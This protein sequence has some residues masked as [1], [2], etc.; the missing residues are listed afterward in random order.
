MVESYCMSKVYHNFNKIFLATT[1]GL[2]I[3]TQDGEL[4]AYSST[5]GGFT[6][7][8]ASTDYIILGTPND[9]LKRIDPNDIELNTASP[10]DITTSIEDFNITNMTSSNIRYLHVSENGLNMTVCTT[11]GVDLIKFHTGYDFHTKTYI[12]GA[13]KC[14]SGYDNLYY[15]VSGTST[16][17]TTSGTDY[18]LCKQEYSP[19]DWDT[20]TKTY[21][22]NDGPFASGIVLYDLYVTDLDYTLIYCATSSGIYI[23]NDDMLE[24]TILYTTTASGV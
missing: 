10:I 18:Y 8:G 11:S 12:E 24:V 22:Y 5:A 15:T 9:G 17:G 7:V 21:N 1:S 2:N 3:Y 19:Y 20:P 14:F 13:L 23:I 16:S 6:T 4:G